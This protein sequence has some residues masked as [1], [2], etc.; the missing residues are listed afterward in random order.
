MCNYYVR[1]KWYGN[2]VNLSQL[3]VKLLFINFMVQIH[4][5]PDNLFASTPLN[6]VFD[7]YLI[8]K[9]CDVEIAAFRHATFGRQEIAID[10]A[11]DFV[12]VHLIRSMSS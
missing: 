9:P 3:L 1:A 10:D 2:S 11:V 6:D 12:D 7:I 5:N 4:A 8:I